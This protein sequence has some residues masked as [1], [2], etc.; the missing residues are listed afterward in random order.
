M[1]LRNQNILVPNLLR[2]GRREERERRRGRR[3]RRRRGRLRM[4]RVVK[5]EYMQIV[6]LAASMINRQ[7]ISLML[8]RRGR[9]N[10]Y[11]DGRRRSMHCLLQLRFVKRYLSL[12]CVS[13]Y[14]LPLCT[15]RACSLYYTEF[16]LYICPPT[17][18]T[19]LI[20]VNKR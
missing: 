8:L 9:L 12:L 4:Q 1:L 10:K 17:S 6:V 2:K 19:V 3:R 11:K 7:S 18:H 13:C 15:R 20:P 16:N 14:Y 5:Q